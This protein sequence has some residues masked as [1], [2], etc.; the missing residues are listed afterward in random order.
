MQQHRVR[1]LPLI[2]ASHDFSLAR[3]SPCLDAFTQM[4][5]FL[6]ETAIES[7]KGVYE[8]AE[9]HMMRHTRMATA[10]LFFST[11]H[12]VSHMPS[13][14]DCLRLRCC[15]PAACIMKAW[16]SSSS[17]DFDRPSARV[18]VWKRVCAT[19]AS[20]RAMR[21]NGSRQVRASH[22]SSAAAVSADT[23]VLRWMSSTC[24]NSATFACCESSSKTYTSATSVP[25]HAGIMSA[26]STSKDGDALAGDTAH[27][28]PS[29]TP[30]ATTVSQRSPA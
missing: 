5:E 11:G 18:F 20:A 4:Q 29:A 10:S 7:G 26:Q 15:G 27:K 6:Q 1:R 2:V 22:S 3:L 28:R 13:S 17:R 21:C 19:S 24:C 30:Q 9:L 12:V 25:R 14:G 23:C 8:H 16:A